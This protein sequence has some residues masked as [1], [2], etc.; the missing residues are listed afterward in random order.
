MESR[1]MTNVSIRMATPSDIPQLGILFDGYRQFYQQPGDIERARDFIGERLARGDSWILV[2][3]LGDDL[4]GFCQL[5]PSFSSTHTSRIAIL[6]DLFV[7]A[8]ARKHGVA[9]SLMQAAEDLGRNLGMSALELSTA[10]NNS[11]AQS[12]YESMGWQRDVEFYTYS[13]ALRT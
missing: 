5:Y 3:Q 13:K 11:T 12:L 7:A 1:E 4:V 2:A 9:K 8:S 10:I 6:N